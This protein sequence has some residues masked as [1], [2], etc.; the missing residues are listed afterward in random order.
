MQLFHHG[1]ESLNVRIRMGGV[2]R[3]HMLL[4]RTIYCRQNRIVSE[5]SERSGTAGLSP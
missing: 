4:R 2:K 5:T 1:L 3:V